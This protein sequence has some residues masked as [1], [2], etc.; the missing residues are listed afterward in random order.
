MT[1]GPSCDDS[2]LRGSEISTNH[3]HYF[4]EV[5]PPSGLMECCSRAASR[6][7]AWLVCLVWPD[8]FR[9]VWF[10]WVWLD[11]FGWIGLVWILVCLRA[12]VLA[13]L[14]ACVL[15][16]CLCLFV[17]HMFSVVVIVFVL[18][19]LFTCCLAAFEQIF[20][21]GILILTTPHVFGGSSKSL[22]ELQP[23]AVVW[24]C[25]MLGCL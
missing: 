14:R 15:R 11:W 12:C 20:V 16:A 3:V 23:V 6:L 25:I 7:L 19:C 9:L 2:R 17:F 24:E 1:V 13:C 22:K 5:K 10:G 4:T 21:Q 8:S 18:V